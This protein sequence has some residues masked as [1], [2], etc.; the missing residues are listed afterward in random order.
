[1]AR[2]G[3]PM[4]NGTDSRNI[5]KPRR[6]FESGFPKLNFFMPQLEIAALDEIT[7]GEKELFIGLPEITPVTERFYRKIKKERLFIDQPL[8]GPDLSG[9]EKL[10]F[11]SAKNLILSFGG[12]VAPSEG[13]GIELISLAGLHALVDLVTLEVSTFLKE[14]SG[15]D[16]LMIFLL[17]ESLTA[18][19]WNRS[20][21]L[22]GNDVNL[23]VWLPFSTTSAG[24]R[25]L[26]EIEKAGHS[27]LMPDFKKFATTCAVEL[28]K[29]RDNYVREE[30]EALETAISFSTLLDFWKE[31]LG[32]N[33]ADAAK[34]LI[35]TKKFPVTGSRSAAGAGCRFRPCFGREIQQRI[36]PFSGCRHYAFAAF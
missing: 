4:M 14:R 24:R 16:Q 18:M 3:L 30:C 2:S 8:F 13:A 5:W 21:R 28:S 20:L 36:D 34:M 7:P 35:E 1:M 17:D 11:D 15:N 9:P 29:N 19:L 31:R 22:F 10:P 6:L 25:L 23:A 26:A 33:L 27:G 12:G 32:R